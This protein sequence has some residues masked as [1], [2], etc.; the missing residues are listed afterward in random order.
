MFNNDS[1]GFLMA[2]VVRANYNRMQVHLGKLGLYPGQPPILFMLW[3]Q[4]GRTQTELC[5][6]LEL[7]PATIT[8]M[9]RRM[10]KAGLIKRKT[11]ENDLRVSR[12]YLTEQGRQ[13][14]SKVEEAVRALDDECF[15]G[16]IEE[17]KVL[18]RRFLIHIRNNL[19][20]S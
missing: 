16:F 12:V 7:K 14:R 4:D 9:L 13:I 17:E 5:E 8:V 20:K 19:I 3:E 6:R 1:L 18:L 11:D 10:E 2:Q 15:D